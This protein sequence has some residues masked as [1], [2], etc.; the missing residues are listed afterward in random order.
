MTGSDGLEA[1]LK[2]AMHSKVEPETE[3]LYELERF[4]LIWWNR[5]KQSISI[6]RL[7][8][9]VTH[10]EMSA[11]EREEQIR[12]IMHM[13]NL[14]AQNFPVLFER[15]QFD[16]FKAVED[17]SNYGLLPSQGQSVLRQIFL[18]QL[19]WQFAIPAHHTLESAEFY[20]WMSIILLLETH[21]EM[22]EKY[23]CLV[24]GASRQLLGPDYSI[25]FA[26]LRALTDLYPLLYHV[27]QA[28]PL[29]EE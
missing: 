15:D 1:K 5:A 2:Q 7:I 14:T 9:T 23:L 25:T 6:H 17:W 10:D 27:D 22:A 18:G 19:G 16:D 12:M 29:L 13:F 3:L 24:L 28:V 11:I 20:H 8:Q 26:V 21:F 4:S